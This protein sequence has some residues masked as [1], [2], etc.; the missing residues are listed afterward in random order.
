[1][2]LVRYDL[3]QGGVHRDP[4]GFGAEALLLLRL[5]GGLLQQRLPRATRHGATGGSRGVRNKSQDL[6]TFVLFGKIS[7]AGELDNV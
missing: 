2:E 1:M 5:A 6:D 7:R 4:V 3:G